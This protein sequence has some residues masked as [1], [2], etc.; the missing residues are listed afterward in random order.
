MERVLSKQREAAGY[1]VEARSNRFTIESG[2]K[3][4]HTP[5]LRRKIMQADNCPRDYSSNYCLILQEKWRCHSKRMHLCV[6]VSD[7]VEA[8]NK[9]T[10]MNLEHTHTHLLHRVEV[11]WMWTAVHVL[12]QLPASQWHPR[13][14]D[15]HLFII[16]HVCTHPSSIHPSD[17]RTIT[18]ENKSKAYCVVCPR[19]STDRVF[20][21]HWTPDTA[22]ELIRSHSY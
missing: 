20:I 15:I 4:E 11:Q 18:K 13:L 7:L 9:F 8:C 19:F 6:A 17:P 12:T 1:L 14:F 5:A 3:G 16:Q 21:P 2:Q 22:N 10:I